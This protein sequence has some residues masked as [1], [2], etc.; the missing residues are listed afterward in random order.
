VG[1][2]A[3]A[4]R[5]WQRALIFLFLAA[6][7]VPTLDLVFGLD[8]NPSPLK[9]DE[10][11]PH[12]HL[13]RSLLK[14]PGALM[15]YLQHNMGFRAT[16]VRLHGRLVWS[17]SG[18][19]PAPETVVRANPWLFLRSERVLDGFRRVDPFSPAALAAWRSTLEARRRWL[20]ERN[21]PYLVVIPPDKES[22]YADAVPSWATRAPGP[23][24]LAQLGG[25]LRAQ[26][27]VQLLDLTAALEDERPTARLFHYTDTH[28]NDLGAFAGY[29]AIAER[30]RAWFPGLRPL[31]S[32]DMIASQVTTPGGDQARICGLQLDLRE[33]QVQLALRGGVL[34]E[35]RLADGRPVTFERLDVRGTPRFETRAPHGEIGSAIIL[36]DSFGEGLIPYLSR[37]FR[38]ATWVWTDDFPTAEIDE[39]RPAVVI[40][41]LVERKLMS[42]EPGAPP[43]GEGRDVR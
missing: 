28:W 9:F 38:A 32:A 37:H 34:D 19:S 5:A 22:I 3:I 4:R 25:E 11:F 8:P 20:A 42:L 21:I 10:P 36:R 35:A 29:R 15:W 13:G 2:P 16:L 17:L 1:S 39:K 27:G 41:E 30:L 31:T 33:P 26:S 7:A 18:D 6:L 14:W 40:Q 24:R 43:P 12:P 23:S